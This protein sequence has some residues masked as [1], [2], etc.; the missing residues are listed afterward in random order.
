MRAPKP[1]SSTFPGVG[2]GPPADVPSI[3]A[4]HGL[5]SDVN[6]AWTWKDPADPENPA[7]HVKW[8]QDPNMLPAIVPHS[9]IL[10]YNYN[11]R[12]QKDAPKTR[13]SL[14]GEELARSVRHVREGAIAS[15]P[16]VFV[17]HSLGGNVIQH[18]SD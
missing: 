16:I 15:R 10:L 17:G 1:T 4:V 6:W 11:S 9:R 8:L 7:L 18:V 14:C 2:L 13:L 12:W 5:G 3:I